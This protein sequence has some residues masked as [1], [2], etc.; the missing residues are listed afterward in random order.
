[1]PRTEFVYNMDEGGSPGHAGLETERWQVT[2]Y[3]FTKKFKNYLYSFWP[4]TVK[5]TGSRD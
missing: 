4:V 1:M 5:G 2:H 3:D